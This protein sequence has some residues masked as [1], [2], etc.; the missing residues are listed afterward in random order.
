MAKGQSGRIVVELDPQL[1]RELYSALA[2]DGST[3]KDW[4]IQAAENYLT[5]RRQPRL[6]LEPHGTNRG[7]DQ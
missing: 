1:K 4:F 3:L 5:E 6:P 2:S 7:S